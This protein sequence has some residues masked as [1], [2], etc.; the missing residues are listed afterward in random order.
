MFVYPYPAVC[1]ETVR[2]NWN[3]IAMKDGLAQNVTFLNVLVV[4]MANVLNLMT[5]IASLD[6]LVKIVLNASP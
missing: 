3:V 1:T 6:G 4:V 2:W 5:A